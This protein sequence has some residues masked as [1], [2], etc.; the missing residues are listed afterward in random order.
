VC[1]FVYA[2]QAM[3]VYR[4]AVGEEHESFA[5]ALVNCGL[6]SPSL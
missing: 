5:T 6:V 3:Q 1:S 4:R 2:V